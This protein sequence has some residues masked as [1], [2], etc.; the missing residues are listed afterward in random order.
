MRETVLDTPSS[1]SSLSLSS[2]LLLNDFLSRDLVC[3]RVCV[4]VCVYVIP[5]VM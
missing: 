2:S 1:S 4:C 5:R 3:A